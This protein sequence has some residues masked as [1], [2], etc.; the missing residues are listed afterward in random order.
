MRIVNFAH[1]GFMM[2]G[3]Y[4]TYVLLERCG[5]DPYIG[6]LAAAAILF[7]L[8]YAVYQVFLRRIAEASDFMQILMTL[9]L[10]LILVAGAQLS[11]GA[12]FHQGRSWLLGSPVRLGEHIALGKPELVSFALA[13]LLAV[14]MF[15]F[16]MRTSLGRALRAIAQNRYAAPLMG[17]NVHRVQALSFGMGLAAA[18]F[19]G[20]LLYPVFYVYPEVGNLFTL[21][22]FVMVVLGGMGSVEGAAAAGLALGIVESLTSLYWGQEWQLAVDFVIFLLVLSLKPSGLFGSQRV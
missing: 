14:A 8:G 6:F 19:A 4:V 12:D 15:L 22:A 16:V 17:I 5:I 2:V 21:K 18:G 1:G 3:M 9:G 7:V 20:G 13:G 10:G 11:F